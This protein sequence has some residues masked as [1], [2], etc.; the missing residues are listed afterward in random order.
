[1][2]KGKV[3][4]EPKAEVLCQKLVH[5]S[6]IGVGVV[7]NRLVQKEGC[8]DWAWELNPNCPKPSELDGNGDELDRVSESKG[9]AKLETPKLE[10]LNAVD[11]VPNPV[12]LEEF[13]NQIN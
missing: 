2:T 8:D 11:E 12:L 9:L 6:P 7:L 3:G 5:P 1:M 4:V 10:E 13:W